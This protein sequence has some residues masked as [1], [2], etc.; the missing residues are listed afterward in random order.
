LKSGQILLRASAARLTH[1]NASVEQ[2]ATQ[3]AQKFEE[4]VA[5]FNQGE[6][7]ACHEAWE[8]VWRELQG[9]DRRFVQGLIQ[10]AVGMYHA[11]RWNVAGARGLFA[12][13]V[14]HL[15]EFGPE[16]GGINIA[17]LLDEVRP[18]RAAVEL[19]EQLPARP[20]LGFDRARMLE[21]LFP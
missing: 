11:S 9:D 20:L 13:G 2:R 15:Q 16:R 18:W 3:L 4:G 8:D 6:Y 12:R 1:Y 7:F 14:A 19:R 5:L 10:V 21:S 17:A